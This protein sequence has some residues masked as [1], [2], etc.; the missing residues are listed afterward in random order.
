VRRSRMRR[1]ASKMHIFVAPDGVAL[2]S[3][4][5]DTNDV[6]RVLDD[7]FNPRAVLLYGSRARGDAIA[8]SDWDL[9]CIAD[10]DEEQ[11]HA[12]QEGGAYLDVFVYPVWP[13]TRARTSCGCEGV[14]CFATRAATHARF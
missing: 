3:R 13:E 6:L 9:A 14:T 7:R 1:S 8:E 2:H 4:P 5:V 10:V 12:W 11:H